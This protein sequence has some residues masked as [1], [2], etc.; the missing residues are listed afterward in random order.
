MGKGSEI[1]YVTEL[2][3]CPYWEPLGNRRSERTT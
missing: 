1:H 2:L 3:T